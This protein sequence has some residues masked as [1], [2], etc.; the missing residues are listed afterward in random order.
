MEIL[1]MMV[2]QP[3]TNWIGFDLVCFGSG[4]EWRHFTSLKCGFST[5]FQIG[6]PEGIDVFGWWM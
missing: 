3:V 6:A 2:V 4:V 5:Q 1:F